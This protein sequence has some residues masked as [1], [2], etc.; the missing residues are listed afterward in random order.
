MGRVGRRAEDWRGGVRTRRREERRRRERS[1]AGK[2]GVGASHNVTGERSLNEDI[3]W[4]PR[5]CL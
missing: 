1:G 2:H 4:V 5:I 3:E